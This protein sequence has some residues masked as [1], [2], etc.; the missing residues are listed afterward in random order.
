ML[1]LLNYL[2]STRITD[3]AEL[4]AKKISKGY[5]KIYN[6]FWIWALDSYQIHLYSK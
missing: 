5:A 4:S 1:L 3:L 6:N 2:L